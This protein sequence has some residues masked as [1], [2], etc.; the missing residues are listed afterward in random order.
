MKDVVFIEAEI[1]TVAPTNKGHAVFVKPLKND[2][3]VPIFVRQLESQAILFGISKISI[4]RPLTHDLITDL[5]QR[6]NVEVERVEIT[7]MKDKT[8]YSRIILKQGM[9][10]FSID[11][12]P[13]DSL[14]IASRTGCVL[15]IAEPVVEEAGVSLSLMQERVQKED[16]AP[17]V[18]IPME[19]RDRLEEE[20]QQAIV[21]ENYEQA[22]RIRDRL[23]QL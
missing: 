16:V 10:R 22:A 9:R 15:Y 11:A 13:S 21:E 1:L 4:H 23:Q 7:D 12:R 14:S 17:A 6:L 19:E 20:L 3:V 8:F 18:D 5:L 2:L